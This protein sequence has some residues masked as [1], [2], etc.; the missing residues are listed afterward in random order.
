MEQAVVFPAAGG[1]P[2]LEGRL[3]L[4]DQAS[5]TPPGAV[6]CH[7]HSLMGGSMDNPLVRQICRALAARGVA[8]LRFNF[9]G[10][11]GSGGRFGGGEA[12]LGDVAG[13]VEFLAS[14]PGVD[15]RRLGLV[16]YSFGAAV[17]LRYAVRD[18]RLRRLVGIAPVPPDV[19]ALFEDD[20]RPK[21]FIAGSADPWASPEALQ[22]SARADLIVLPADHF[23]VGREETV[24]ALVVDFLG[25]W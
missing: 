14:H 17:G 9:R 10:V 25:E 20:A 16:G 24:A 2:L 5:D 12:E 19:V 4:P 13:A 3:H 1:E 11:G 6:V 8:A 23:F 18:H 22:G 21:R 7:P 15:P